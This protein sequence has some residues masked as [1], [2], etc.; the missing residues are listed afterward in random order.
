MKILKYQSLKLR[1]IHLFYCKETTIKKGNADSFYYTADHLNCNTIKESTY[2]NEDQMIKFISSLEI[3]M[4]KKL[5]EKAAIPR[6]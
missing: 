5:V 1:N 6:S 4:A 2:Q 3:Y